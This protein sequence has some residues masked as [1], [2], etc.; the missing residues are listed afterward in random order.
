MSTHP[1]PPIQYVDRVSGRV[2]TERVFGGETLRFLYGPGRTLTDHVLS[3][4]LANRLYGLLQRS[5]RSRRKIESFVATLGINAS[6]AELPLDAYRSLDDFFTR[7]LRVG[8]RPID[9][10]P[11]HLVSPGD[12]RAV[13]FASLEDDRVVVKGSHVGLAELLGDRAL[14]ARFSGGAALVLRLAPADYHRFHF[15]EA[16]L[17][18]PGVALSGPLHSVHP[19]ALEAG[20]PSFRNKRVVTRLATAAFG[21]LGLVDVGALCVGTIVQTYRPGQVQRGDEKGYFR[22]GGSTVILL[23]EPGKL[24]FDDDI[25]E[26]T[27]RGMESRV[28][29]GSR[30]A[31][32]V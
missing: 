30:I 31:K 9:L 8:A 11:G 23:A 28:L 7:H 20:A 12:G 29:M 5:P 10:T 19:I 27:A 14:A 13:A 32:A 6:E 25:L 16:G 24:R 4:S 17:V 18:G 3:R 21:I 2:E 26:A 22:F 1:S 15:P